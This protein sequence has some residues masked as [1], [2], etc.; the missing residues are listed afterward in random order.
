MPRLLL[1]LLLLAAT[2]VG[3][4]QPA[5]STKANFQAAA[6]FSPKKLEKMIFT[7][8]V[9]AHWLKKS[10]RFWYMYETTEGKKWYIVDPAKGERKVLFDNDKLAA[11][12]S[13]IVKD[14]FEAKHLGLDS[15]RF[16]KDENW[17]QFEVK[18]SQD[19]DK[20]DSAA[21]GN[22]DGG[23][24]GGRARRGAAATNPTTKDK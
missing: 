1:T 20:K 14:P 7:T 2:F 18:S 19:V 23:T 24:T 13:R 16:I 21:A 10:T 5:L 8:Q 9:E 15:M 17:I 11:A 12:I 6:R 4:A 22:N 3:Y